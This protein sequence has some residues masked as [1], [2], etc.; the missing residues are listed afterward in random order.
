MRMVQ[1]T[2]VPHT[3]RQPFLSM[4]RF[5]CGEHGNPHYHGF[6]VGA[7]NP[8][9][10]RVRADAGEEHGGDE[11]PHSEQGGSE[12]PSDAGESPREGVGSAGAA[13]AEGGACPPAAF[14]S[15]F[16]TAAGA[17][18]GASGADGARGGVRRV[19]RAR[20]RRRGVYASSRVLAREGTLPRLPENMRERNAEV[21]SQSAMEAAFAEYFGELVSEWNPLFDE[22]GRMRFLWHEDVGA[23]DVCM[24]SA[25][26][27]LSG[28]PEGGDEDGAGVEAAAGAA[29]REAVGADVGGAAAAL[30]VIMLLL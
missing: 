26:M 15:D 25:C 23:H 16:P 19:G 2:L 10:Q 9:L 18:R 30:S 7:G 22:R 29:G 27:P 21:Q 8:R 28:V 5:E 1:P 12:D 20:G 6:S 24:E 13:V 3:E 11:A 14:A 17:G 4:A